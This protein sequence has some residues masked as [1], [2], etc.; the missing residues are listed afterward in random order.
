MTSDIKLYYVIT[1]VI[2]LYLLFF[3]CKVSLKISVIQM[4]NLV[5]STSELLY[6][7]KLPLV[8]TLQKYIF[9]RSMFFIK[10]VALHLKGTLLDRR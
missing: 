5:L 10:D 3:N 1:D 4:D 2:A 8:G 9:Y 7:Q 6:L